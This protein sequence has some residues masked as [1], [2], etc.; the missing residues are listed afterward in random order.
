MDIGELFKTH[1]DRHSFVFERQR[2]K[3]AVDAGARLRWNFIDTAQAEVASNNV[4]IFD[5]EVA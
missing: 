3:T 2:K 1:A 4:E 5:V